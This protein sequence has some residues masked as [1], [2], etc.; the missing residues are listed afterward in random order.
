ML[1]MAKKDL[2]TKTLSEKKGLMTA[3]TKSKFID[4]LFVLPAIALL[5]VFTYYPVAKLVQISFTD[6]NLL[7][8]TWIPWVRFSSPW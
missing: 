7:N 5:A 2:N 8:P 4:F 3:R 1:I 6:W